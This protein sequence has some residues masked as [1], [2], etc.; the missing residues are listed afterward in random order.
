MDITSSLIVLFSPFLSSPHL[1]SS[2][3]QL[4]IFFFPWLLF[5]SCP[6]IYISPSSP[7]ILLISHHPPLN[8]FFYSSLLS[9]FCPFTS[10]SP[11]IF[12]SSLFIIPS[13]ILSCPPILIRL[14]STISPL[15]KLHLLSFVEH[16]QKEWYHYLLLHW[17]P[18]RWA[19][20]AFPGPVMLLNDKTPEFH[21]KGNGRHL[22][23]LGPPTDWLHLQCIYNAL[24]NIGNGSF[25][26]CSE[27]EW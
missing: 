12:F 20:T 23:V 11:L 9:S 5:S 6:L 8:Y 2:S 17:I 27:G 7:H 10:S 19:T 22:L 24:Y 15:T 16:W 13:S 4:L 18:W 26:I 1:L 14:I 25:F 21:H 3:S